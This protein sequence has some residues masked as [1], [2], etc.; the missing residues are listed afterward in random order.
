MKIF[1]DENIPLMTVRV[2]RE[3]G[4]D[5]RDIRGTAQ[6][7]ITDDVLWEIAQQEGRLLITT[8]KGFTQYRE[9]L[10]HGILIVRLRQ[11]NRHKIHQRVMQAMT[12]FAAEEWRDLLVVM[13]DVMQSVW[14][15]G[16]GTD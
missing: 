9:E 12:Q 13:R 2:L 11:P 16:G 7:G 14:R 5:V 10:H 15:T 8:D 1:V 3:M 6:Q 4:H